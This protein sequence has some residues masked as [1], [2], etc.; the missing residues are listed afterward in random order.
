MSLRDGPGATTG[1]RLA[2][3][4]DYLRSERKA[5]PSGIPRAGANAELRELSR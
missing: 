2:M 1:L 4:Q 3:L 5:E